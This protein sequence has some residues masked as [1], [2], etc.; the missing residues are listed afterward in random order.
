MNLTA[1]KGREGT[2]MLLLKWKLL[3]NHWQIIIS[4]SSET[5]L[6]YFLVLGECWQ[7]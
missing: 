3:K 5:T 2:A 7:Q 6:F 4:S 1:V